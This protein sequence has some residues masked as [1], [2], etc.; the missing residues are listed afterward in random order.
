MASVLTKSPKIC[1]IIPYY[2][3]WPSWFNY[4]LLT[5]GTNPDI[6]WIFISDLELPSDKPKNVN[7][8]KLPLEELIEL[9][10]SRLNTR[11]QITHPY[12]LAD[13]KPAYGS[14]FKDYIKDYSFWGYGDIDMVYGKISNFLFAEIFDTFDIISP[15]DNFVPGHFCLFRNNNKINDLFRVC[16]NWKQVFQSPKYYYFDERFYPRGFYISDQNIKRF[17]QK[18][19]ERHLLL[20]MF[21]ENKLVSKLLQ[22]TSNFWQKKTDNLLDFNS[23]INYYSNL[24]KIKLWQKTIFGD[25]VMK[26]YNGEKQYILNWNSGRLYDGNKELLYYHFQLAKYNDNFK[27]K[28]EDESSFSISVG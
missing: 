8:I 19:V 11:I 24:E 18:R 12:K 17:N 25:D 9:A 23:A 20:T 22:K 21:L 26:K 15:H 27:I 4:F 28:K 10:S 5:C 7:L 16:S 1:I 14:I 13:L 2:G 6:D 3:T